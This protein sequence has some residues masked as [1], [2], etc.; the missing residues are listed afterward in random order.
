MIFNDFMKNV[1]DRL[2]M[3]SL[4]G[5]FEGDKEKAQLYIY[6]LK[7][8]VISVRYLEPLHSEMSPEVL[9]TYERL[10]TKE[11]GIWT[12]DVINDMNIDNIDY[13][14]YMNDNK[15][16][17]C[18]FKCELK[19]VMFVSLFVGLSEI[20]EEKKAEIKNIQMKNYS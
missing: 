3:K 2:N 7:N 10:K 20:I 5:Y 4:N 13:K 9:F 18:Q 17:E 19:E 11:E 16:L 14:F 1:E 6:N 8:E 12:S 15:N